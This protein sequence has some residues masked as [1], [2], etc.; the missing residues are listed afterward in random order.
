MLRALAPNDRALAVAIA[1]E[2]C[3]HAV[4]LD[5]L[6]DAQTREPL[7]HDLKVRQALRIAL[8]QALGLRVAEHAAIATVLPL[9]SGG[10]RRLLHGVFGAVMRSGAT[11]PPV[12]ELPL[13]VAERWEAAWGAEACRAIAAALAAPP[14][15]DLSLRDA[16]ETSAWAERL[17]A[18][19]VAPGH[20]RLPRGRAVVDL[21]GFGDGAWWVQDLAASLPA[22]LLGDGGGRRVL[23]VGAAPG[24]KTMQLAAAGWQVTALD[25]SARRAQRLRDNLTRVGLDA[26]VV[27][28]DGRALPPDRQYDAV[29]L[30]AP[31]SATG[32]ARRHPDVLH[33]IDARDIDDRAALQVE[34][35]DAAARA[36]RPGGGLVF[37]TCSLEPEEGEA[38]LERFL[39]AHDDWRLA[40]VTADELPAGF[41]PTADG[42]VRT[43]P[44]MLAEVG[45]LD[46]FFIARLERAG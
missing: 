8:V 7:G 4:S 16:S 14:P 39:A 5:A 10:P 13:A 43:L 29:L 38:Q 44:S 26:E 1:T 37:A 36:V 40:P 35:I 30:D 9:L 45:G 21:P 24:G 18:T 22:R 11:L 17:G 2:V 41:A 3:R 34:L 46:G 28:G 33:R 6:I 19:S 12:P 15:L 23:D 31:C 42:A 20:L 32:I 25:A 27:V